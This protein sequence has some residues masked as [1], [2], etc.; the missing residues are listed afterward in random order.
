MHRTLRWL[1]LAPLS[2]ACLAVP[3]GAH[4][5]KMRANQCAAGLQ[6]YAR[7]VFDAV[8]AR[9]QPELMLR[10]V[11]E[12]RTRELVFTDRLMVG[13]AR[14]AAEAASQCLRIARDC[15]ADHC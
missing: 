8:I 9:P 10:S 12:A 4:A 2:V 15:T 14:P 6:P 3:F 7:L 1:S 5:D 13:D 11:I